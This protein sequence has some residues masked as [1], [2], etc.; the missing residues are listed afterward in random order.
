[1]DNLAVHRSNDVKGRMDELSIGYIYSPPYSP[2]YNPIE[3]VFSMFKRELK[4]RR[5]KAIIEGR[6]FKTK[7][8]IKEVFQNIDM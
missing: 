8:N 3:S 4:V 5:L 6:H 2:D 1:M 7:E